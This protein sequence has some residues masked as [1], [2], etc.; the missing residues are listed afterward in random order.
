MQHMVYRLI[1]DLDEDPITP[2][3]FI[4][5]GQL[6]ES[7]MSSSDNDTQLFRTSDP[8]H[9]A[10]WLHDLRAIIPEAPEFLVELPASVIITKVPGENED[11]WF[12]ICFG[13][14]HTLLDY[15]KVLRRWGLKVA[16]NLICAKPYVT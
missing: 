3:H 7:I 15:E 1:P 6:F 14:G 16:L 10:Q 5:S 2:D 11:F 12:A 8:S 9:E 13:H 4:S